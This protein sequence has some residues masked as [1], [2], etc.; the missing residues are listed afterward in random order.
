M[1]DAN[2]PGCA[3]THITASGAIDEGTNQAQGNL[4]HAILTPAAAVATLTL[5]DNTSGTGTILA[6]LQAAANGAS[7]IFNPAKF[8]TYSKGLW[9]VITGSGAAAD[10][11]FKNIRSS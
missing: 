5:Y 6:Q 8:P 3:T 4:C 9:A 10:I 11:G 2:G 1:S 7:V